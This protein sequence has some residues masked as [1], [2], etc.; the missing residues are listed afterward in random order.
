MTQDT[1]RLQHGCP[2]FACS[3]QCCINC[4]GDSL[5]IHDTQL[6]RAGQICWNANMGDWLPAVTNTPP[7]DVTQV[8]AALQKVKFL[9]IMLSCHTQHV[10]HVFCTA[11]ATAHRPEMVLQLIRLTVVNVWAFPLFA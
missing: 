4:W 7:Q 1:L 2:Q 3:V 6:A 8:Q 5:P 10:V 11:H 9:R